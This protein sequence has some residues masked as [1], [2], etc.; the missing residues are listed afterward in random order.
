MK[1][2]FM[3]C[4]A[5]AALFAIASSATAI[6]C[7]LDQR[8]GA[9]LLVPYFQ[10][11]IDPATGAVVGSG[12]L[13]R[14]T[15][16]T[17]GNASAAPMVAHVSVYDRFS[18]IVLDFNVALTG[19]DIQSMAMSQIITG[20][21]PV[22]LNSSGDDV[23]Q[24]AG[25]AVYPSSDGFLRVSPTGPTNV[26]ATNQ[27][28]TNGTTN[29]S[30]TFFS[31]TEAL[32]TDC[33]D[34][35]EALAIGYL[36]VDHANY[37]N[38]SDPT[39]PNYFIDDAIGMENNLF[40]EVIFTSGNGLP[41]YGISTVNL[42]AD[43]TL[44]AATEIW[45]G[46]G[47]VA[48]TFYARYLDLSSETVCTNCGSG[49]PDTD[50]DISAPWD[51]GFGDQREPL[52]LRWAARW[53]DLSSTG[54]IT[55]NYM[56]WRA[57]SSFSGNCSVDEPLSTLTFFDEDE[58]TVTQGVCPSPCS[59]PQF[60]F[61]YETQQRNITDF[62]HPVADAGWVQIDFTGGT[63]LDQAWVGYAFLGS[64]ALESVLIPATQLDPS[65]CNPLGIT[66]LQ[67][68]VPVIPSIPTGT[69]L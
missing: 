63:Q 39:D 12:D 25:G 18:S 16:L 4:L 5:V 58:N 48:R 23:C 7:T 38:L 49:N 60:N 43:V 8:P 56:V 26:P 36:V 41:T 45:A 54:I 47:A 10:V 3:T 46:G 40:G 27:D 34:N 28:N 21:L 68:I 9:T 44:G 61:P 17:I 51:E 69:G 65:S 52:G 59:T 14:D 53:F 57:S 30:G 62:Q 67:T 50:L 64:I 19:F 66:G 1:K 29:Y 13:S 37:C 35:V 15:I 31:V 33:N 24:R 42:E 11:S 55:T 22:T 20:H 2:T 32:A 6:T